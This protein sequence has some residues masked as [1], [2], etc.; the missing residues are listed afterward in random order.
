MHNFAIFYICYINIKLG[1]LKKI[2]GF[3]PKHSY[4]ASTE[5]SYSIFADLN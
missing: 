3:I 2:M 5:Y 1:M 4:S